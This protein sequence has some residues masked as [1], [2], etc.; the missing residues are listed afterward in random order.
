MSEQEKLNIIKN[1][2][3]GDK[4]KAK[5]WDNI[6]GIDEI[7]MDFDSLDEKPRYV[8]LKNH[9]HKS[10]FNPNGRIDSYWIHINKL[11]LN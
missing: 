1:F 6:I 8:N 10:R 4:V 5:I 7:E 3:K 11:I 9:I 2:K